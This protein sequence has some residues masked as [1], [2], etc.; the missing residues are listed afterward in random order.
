MIRRGNKPASRLFHIS[1]SAAIDAAWTSKIPKMARTSTR[2]PVLNA[3]VLIKSD[4]NQ[5]FR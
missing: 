2:T 3:I 5:L 1:V 4:V